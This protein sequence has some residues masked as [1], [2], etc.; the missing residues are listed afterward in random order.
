MAARVEVQAASFAYGSRPVF[1]GLDLSLAAGE[2]VSLLGPNGCGKTTLLRCVAGLLPPGEGKILLDGKE[3]TTLDETHRAR[4]LGFVFQEHT[5]L[6]PYTVLEVVRMGRAPHLGL[7]AVPSAHDTEIALHALETVGL[8][9]LAGARYTQISGGER[10]LA[11][12]ARALAQEPQVLLL[13][14]P[15]SHLDFGNQML[16]LE[17][18]RRLAAERD[19]AVLMAT[20]APDHALFVADRVALMKDGG[21]LALG[22]PEAVMTEE[23]LRTIYRID[24]S[25]V[26]VTGKD[27]SALTRA[28]VAL[29]GGSRGNEVRR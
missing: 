4:I 10:Q 19:L 6:F 7:F 5:V 18:V 24:V 16:V 26:T 25:I 3:L 20:H 2:I 21:F 1:R 9:A 8:R 22:T 14:E 27:G 28:A 29:P 15:T 11:L 13:D 17:T 23:N 12:V